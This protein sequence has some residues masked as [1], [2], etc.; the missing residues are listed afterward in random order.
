MGDLDF[1]PILDEISSLLNGMIFSVMYFGMHCGKNILLLKHQTKTIM[2]ALK[3]DIQWYVLKLKFVLNF[4]S[5][6]N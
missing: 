2:V 4:V 3:D 6:Q 1:T 5:T